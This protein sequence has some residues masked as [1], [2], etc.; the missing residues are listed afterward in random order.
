MCLLTPFE[1]TDILHRFQGVSADAPLL[2]Q[3]FVLRSFLEFG[4]PWI[5]LLRF[6]LLN[7]SRRWTL[8]FPNFCVKHRGL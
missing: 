5:S 4:S 3:G 7:E 8:L 1:F 2:V 6:A